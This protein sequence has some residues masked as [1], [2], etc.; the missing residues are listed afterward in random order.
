MSSID[1]EPLTRVRKKTESNGTVAN[2]I[3]RQ[4]LKINSTKKTEIK[5]L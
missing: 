3:E 4:L 1:Y 2:D 5:I